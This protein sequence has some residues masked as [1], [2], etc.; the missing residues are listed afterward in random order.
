L[1]HTSARPKEITFMV[2]SSSLSA[3][4][5]GERLRQARN[6]IG[7]TQQQVAQQLNITRVAYGHYERGAREVALDQLPALAQVLG[8]SVED[9]L[10]L[11]PGPAN[12][13]EDRLL[14]AFRRLSQE[15]KRFV[16]DLFAEAA[17]GQN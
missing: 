9:L 2:G 7:L 3:S 8:T 17:E 10:G 15:Q 14:K 11:S 6:K 12:V 5:L 4:S 1:I 13:G 16:L